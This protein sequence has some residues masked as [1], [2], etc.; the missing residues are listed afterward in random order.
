MQVKGKL[1]RSHSE[2]GSGRG[3]NLFLA[4]SDAMNSNNFRLPS[5]SS[6]QVAAPQQATPFQTRLCVMPTLSCRD[7]LAI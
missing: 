3:R 7:S 6:L 4:A 5:D 1:H 2:E